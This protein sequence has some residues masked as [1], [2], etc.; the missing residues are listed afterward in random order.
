M[1][2]RR[3]IVHA[4]DRS[5]EGTIAGIDDDGVLLV[6]VSDGATHRVIAGDVEYI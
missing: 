2:G 5:L 3:V 1:A 4:F 6:N